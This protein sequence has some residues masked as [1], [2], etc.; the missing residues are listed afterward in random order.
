[1][2]ETFDVNAI[3]AWLAPRLEADTVTLGDTRRP[4]GQGFSAET[5]MTTAECRRSG[6]RTEERLVLRVESP[7]PAIY[8][9]QADEDMPE[10]EIQHRVMTALATS[11][12]VPVAP[13]VGYEADPAVAGTPFF[14]MR[15]V[16]GVVPIESPPYTTEGFFTEATPEQRGRLVADG[17]RELG[18]LHAVDWQAAGLRWLVPAG[19]EPGTPAQLALWEG[20]GEQEL[21][22]RDHPRLAEA[23]AWLRR[24]LPA[25][26]SIGLCWGDP[27]PGNIIWRD[28]RVAC[29]TDFEA[30]CIAAPEQDLAWWL[31][32]D[33]T[34]HELSGTGHLPGEPDRDEQ[35]RLYFEQSGREP[36]DTTAHEIFAAARYCVIVVRVMNRLEA[37]GHLPADSVIWRDNPASACLDMLLDERR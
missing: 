34:T 15:F 37:R 30:A 19:V 24:E 28:F 33:R 4:S 35:R 11:S 12:P 16:D 7:D 36:V 10:I 21:R 13:L 23:W 32:F 9:P 1:M 20:Y 31:M 17:L 22:G 5:I 3:E 26:R 6:E 2:T 14:V 27:R 8:P 25:D 29:T 18:A